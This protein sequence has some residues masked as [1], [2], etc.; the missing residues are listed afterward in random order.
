MARVA[1]DSPA[2]AEE[3]AVWAEDAGDKE[4]PGEGAHPRGNG[5]LS[6]SKTKL[7]THYTA[8]EARP[9]EKLKGSTVQWYC[10]GESGYG[11]R[12]M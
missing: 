5:C 6:L 11:K 2:D 7:F 4:I 12:N 1:V 8:L 10:K 9:C 3:V